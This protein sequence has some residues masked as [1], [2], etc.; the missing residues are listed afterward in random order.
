MRR[1]IARIQT[2]H[3]LEENSLFVYGE[4]ARA[5]KTSAIAEVGGGIATDSRRVR[6]LVYGADVDQ[7][8]RFRSLPIVL[9][10]GL[11]ATGPI[12]T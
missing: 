4:R 2:A 5:R 7:I 12:K 6:V 10:V 1:A 11:A 9:A 8:T 3:V